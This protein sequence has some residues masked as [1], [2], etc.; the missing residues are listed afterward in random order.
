[1][2]SVR[3]IC[4]PAGTDILDARLRTLYLHFR[5]AAT[6]LRDVGM[7]LD[8]DPDSIGDFLHLPAFDVLRFAFMPRR[9]RNEDD[10][11]PGMRG[12][13]P[14]CLGWAVVLEALSYGEPGAILA[15]AGPGLSRDVVEFL[16]DQAQQD[17]F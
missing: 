7:A 14:S 8:R 4:L 3:D 11:P 13:E 1:M 5:D 16:G 15:N 10:S 9:Y 6:E 2:T 17:L 12:F